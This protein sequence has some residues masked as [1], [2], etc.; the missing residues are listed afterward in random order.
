MQDVLEV[1]ALSVGLAVA[2][3]AGDVMLSQELPPEMRA[4]QY[5]MEGQRALKHNDPATAVEAFK[6]VAALPV[7]PSVDFAFWY[8]QALV[9]HGISQSD[10]GMVNKG[11]GF[12]TQYLLETGRESDHQA[13][14]VAWLARAEGH[15]LPRPQPPA[16][17]AEEVA[18]RDDTAQ[19]QKADIKPEKCDDKLWGVWQCSHHADGS[20]IHLSNAIGEDGIEVVTLEWKPVTIFRLGGFKNSYRVDRKWRTGVTGHQGETRVSCRGWNDLGFRLFSIL[21]RKSKGV[22]PA[23]YQSF[24]VDAASVLWWSSGKDY[25]GKDGKIQS[26]EEYSNYCERVKN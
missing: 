13:D 8:G 1:L 6:K 9:E 7:D 23:S 22:F 20:Y 17:E 10:V 19:E 25:R 18:V 11:E 2:F 16:E 12:L 15:G 14:A 5:L 21:E 3:A 4:D 24:F 26:E